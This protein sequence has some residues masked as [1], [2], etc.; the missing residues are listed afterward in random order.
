MNKRELAKIPCTAP[1]WMLKKAK[2]T[3]KDTFLLRRKFGN[4]ATYEFYLTGKLEKGDVVPEFIVFKEKHDWVNYSPKEE[5]W[6]NAKFENARINMEQN[7][8]IFYSTYYISQYKIL[9][10][11]RRWQEKIG[12]KRYKERVRK[13]KERVKKI[14]ALV[15]ELPDDFMDFVENNLMKEA[16]YIVYNR[17]KDTAYCTRCN[18]KYT[19]KELE[20]RNSTK[21]EHMKEYQFCP[22]CGV[23][24]RQLSSGLSRN[25]KEFRRGLEIMQKCGSGVVVREFEVT[26]E[27][28]EIQ[29]EKK[30][31]MLTRVVE[32]HRYTAD[33]KGYRKFEE[34]VVEVGK[35]Y[36]SEWKDRSG[37]GFRI[38]GPSDGL[39]YKKN[40]KKVLKGT[41]FGYEGIGEIIREMI[42]KTSY[43]S[44]MESVI[45]RAAERTYLE[46]FIKAGLK[47]LAVNDMQGNTYYLKINEKETK[48][49]KMLGINKGELRII[50]EAEKQATALEVI[51]LL[52]EQEKVASEELIKELYKEK[53]NGAGRFELKKLI[54]KNACT[55]KALRYINEQG[56]GVNDFVDHLE[57]MEKLGIQRKKNNLYPGDF[58]MF[59]QEE[60]EEDILRNNEK[61]AGTVRKKFKKTYG[62]WEN[63]IEKNGVITEG[64]GY[65]IIL[66]ENPIDIKVEG[67]CLH[68]CVG[69]Y[70]D[71]AAEG[72]T[73]IFYVRESKN[74]R[75]YTAE[76][77]DGK[78][79]QIRA[80]YNEDPEEEARKLAEQFT[81]EL[82]AAEKK[83]EKLKKNRTKST[84]QTAIAV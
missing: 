42:D 38:L 10:N 78:L 8:R 81:K 34:T 29:G 33:R 74:I 17:K 23:W 46:Q 63:I 32:I 41:D 11:L 77:R 70:V 51:Q 67:R 20:I 58:K 27:F 31:T 4:V 43:N 50:R 25:G 1:D 75:L 37:K 30:E 19:L 57:L 12:H 61:I 48:V 14:M 69:N 68:H 62:R 47:E 55:I 52:K 13:E 35:E 83:E 36:E 24:M 2:N 73:F 59:H 72:K 16:N 26:R 39:Y 40:I 80:A 64:N 56:I 53:E 84:K 18:E 49:T 15:P 79:I 44:G 21:A 28:E 7:G 9:R 76:Y 6:T 5:G 3:E 60:V 82:A 54:E 65:R 71:M 66:P 22:K 45:K